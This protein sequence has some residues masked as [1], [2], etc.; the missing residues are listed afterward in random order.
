MNSV[1]LSQSKLLPYRCMGDQHDTTQGEPS[2]TSTSET[3]AFGLDQLEAM[4]QRLKTTVWI[5][6][7]KD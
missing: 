4:E 2:G 3:S 1:S 7:S 6:T 5:F